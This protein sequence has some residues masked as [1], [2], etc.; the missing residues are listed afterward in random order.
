MNNDRSNCTA[1]RHGDYSAYSWHRCRCP[2][3]REAWRLYQK[4]TRE[5]RQ[6]SA[7]TNATGTARRLQALCALGYGWRDLAHRLGWHSEVI[8][9]I[10]KLADPQVLRRTAHAINDL[11]D[12]LAATPA[13]ETR[14][15]KY[16]R[17]VARRHGWVPPLAWDDDPGPHHIDDPDATPNIGAGNDA[18]PDHEV[19]ARA[20]A[21]ELYWSQLTHS[22]RVETVRRLLATTTVTD[23]ARR[24][25]MSVRHL[26][27]FAERHLNHKQV[28]A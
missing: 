21:G 11:Y 7:Y 19:V 3:A 24:L 28:A 26:N 27:R 25:H 8:A 4:R 17:T 6:P 13:D 1:A 14:G 9:R 18:Q 12:Q 10:A 5:G 16:A 15:A 2:E 23:A 22:D 20:V